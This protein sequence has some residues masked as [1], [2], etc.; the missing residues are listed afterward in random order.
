MEDE[1]FKVELTEKGV[2]WLRRLYGIAKAILI[3]AVVVNLI[4]LYTTLAYFV[5][6]DRQ[7]DASSAG[8]WRNLIY[9]SYLM[10]SFVL[11][12]VQIVFYRRFAAK[13]MQAIEARDSAAF[14]N[15]FRW[16]VLQSVLF[17]IQI[18]IAFFYLAYA[19]ILNRG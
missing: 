15:S 1:L 16:L 10:I 3:A 6:S 17:L 12:I 18:L 14:N 5:Q 8:R 19:Y 4:S 9:V 2:Y 7:P 13:A 11:Q